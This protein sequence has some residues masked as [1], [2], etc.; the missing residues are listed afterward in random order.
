MAPL[1]GQPAAGGSHFQ[2]LG[3]LTIDNAHETVYYFSKRFA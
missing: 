1:P 2:K 3:I